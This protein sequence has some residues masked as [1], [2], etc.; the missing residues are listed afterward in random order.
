MPW[1]KTSESREPG[2][3]PR[4]TLL[5]IACLL[6]ATASSQRPAAPPAIE[7][8]YKG[9]TFSMASRDGV[10]VMIAPLERT[11]LEYSTAQVWIS[12]TSP[13][14]LPIAPQGF[15]ATVEGGNV[16]AAA[17]DTVVLREIQRHA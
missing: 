14:A 1:S 10:T 4:S 2:P 15:A 13:R 7:V 5:L 3:L 16:S 6:A 12:N 9:R 11:I 17:Q 8:P